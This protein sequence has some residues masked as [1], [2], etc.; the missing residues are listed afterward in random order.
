LEDLGVALL[1]GGED[2]LEAATD[3]VL[4]GRRLAPATATWLAGLRRGEVGGDVFGILGAGAG[5]GFQGIRRCGW[6]WSS[7]RRRW[8]RGGGGEEAFGA[9][10]VSAP[11]GV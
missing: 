9:V 6:I 4:H 2:V 10:A 1:D 7:W 11:D 3:E 5:F 8:R